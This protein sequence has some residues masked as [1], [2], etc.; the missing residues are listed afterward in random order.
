MITKDQILEESKYF[1]GKNNRLLKDKQIKRR[2]LI[3]ILVKEGLFSDFEERSC[4]KR[5][6]KKRKIKFN[7]QATK[8]E[9]VQAALKKKVNFN[10]FIL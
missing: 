1:L 10:E 3:D 5:E 8:E 7:Q 9:L 2:E 4:L 6:L